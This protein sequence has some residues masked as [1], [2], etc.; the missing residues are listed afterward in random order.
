MRIFSLILLLTLTVFSCSENNPDF[1]TTSSK[2]ESADESYISEEIPITNQLVPPPPPDGSETSQTAE[3]KIIKTAN[4]AWETSDLDATHSKILKAASQYKGLVQNDNS[5]KDY[6]RFYKNITVRVPSENF[7]P[8]LDAISEGVSYYDTKDIS[9]QD[10]SE[11]F[12]D[13][14]ARLKAKREL[15]NRYLELLKSAKTVED[16]LSI[17]REL[18][19]IRE[20]IEAKQG[21][22]QFLENRV[23][24]STITI[25]FYKTTSETG[26]TQ[27]YGQKIK[28]ALRGGWDGISVFFIGLLYIWPLFFLAV[29]IIVLVRYSIKRKKSK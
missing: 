14:Q 17:E 9:Q 16:M 24:L 28:N 13:L 2:M 7:Q 6:N 25:N 20:E 8:F 10:V 4:L 26:V 22:L 11:E 5:G 18:A 27:S 29:L 21:R 15:E 12:V 1:G 3:Q 23:S 19:N